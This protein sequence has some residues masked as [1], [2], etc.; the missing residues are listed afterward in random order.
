MLH[1]ISDPHRGL[2]SGKCDQIDPVMYW[3]LCTSL[4]AVVVCWPLFVLA[5]FV[6]QFSTDGF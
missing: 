6:L 3:Q 4:W 1:F 5:A 2:I